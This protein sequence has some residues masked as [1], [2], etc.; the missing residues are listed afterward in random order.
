MTR[1]SVTNRMIRDRALHRAST[2]GGAETRTEEGYVD[3]KIL[4]AREILSLT[5][6]IAAGNQVSRSV[7]ADRSHGG[8]EVA[9]VAIVVT[10]VDGE[11]R[12]LA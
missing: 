9:E 8:G 4:D 11:I 6:L 10:V 7:H 2:S 5:F 3:T 12:P 1:G